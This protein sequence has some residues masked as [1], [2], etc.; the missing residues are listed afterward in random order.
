[1]IALIT[2]TGGRFRQIN[3]CVEF[4]K[5]Q[6]Y[7]GDVLWVIVDDV[8]PTTIDFIPDNFR[9][10]WYVIK[11]YPREKWRPGMNT[12]ARNLLVGINVVKYYR[13]LE[14]VFIIED[15]D[16]YS[17]VYLE[18]MLEKLKGYKAVGQKFTIYYHVKARR[19]RKN[20]NSVHASLFQTAFTSDMIPTFESVCGEKATFIDLMFFRKMEP[21]NVHLFDGHPLAIG[22][23]GIEG[24]TG[25][26]MGHRAA[27]RM[28]PDPDFKMLRKWI[29]DDYEYYG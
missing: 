23:K 26:G 21:E 15:D 17:P 25:I 12:Q 4:M 20:G 11:K 24:R 8:L 29:G 2:P 3:L 14:A 28:K 18:R 27:H 1:M 22:I 7:E 5:R 9:A 16:Y 13:D 10:T 6:T 19:W